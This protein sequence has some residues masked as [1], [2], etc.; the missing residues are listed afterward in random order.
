MPFCRQDVPLH[1][2]KDQTEQL[3]AYP[4]AG[5]V[6]AQAA[7]NAGLSPEEYV[8]RC[9]FDLDEDPEEKLRIL[10]ELMEARGDL[11]ES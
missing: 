11:T 10:S 3:F 4:Q 6:L 1:H 8:Q 7:E 5:L 9:L 2:M